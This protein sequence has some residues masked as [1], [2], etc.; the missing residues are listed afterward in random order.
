MIAA[1]EALRLERARLSN[2]ERGQLAE[3]LAEVDRHIRETMTF[4]GPAPL[5]IPVAR[6]S[7]TVMKAVCVDLTRRGW[8]ATG[9][10]MSLPPR[11]RGGSPEPHHW[12]LLLA[13]LVEAYPAIDS[14]PAALLQ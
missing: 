2:E 6:A 9:Q 10:L 5:D 1:A 3:L 8:S 11:F 13:P 4:A 14:P 7:P 12:M